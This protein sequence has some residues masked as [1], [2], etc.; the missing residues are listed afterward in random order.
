MPQTK[1]PLGLL[2]LFPELELISDQSL[3]EAIVTL[4]NELWEESEFTDLD[5]MSVSL[6]Y[7]YPHIKHC[8]GILRAALAAADAVQVV[9]PQVGRL[10]DMPVGVDRALETKLLNTIVFCRHLIEF[11]APGRRC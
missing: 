7:A 6:H 1:T 10:Q 11:P 4:W 2:G 5:Q 9:L 8:Q 3:R